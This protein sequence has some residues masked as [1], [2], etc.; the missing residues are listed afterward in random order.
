M[1]TFPPDYPRS[2]AVLLGT[3]V[4]RDKGLRQ[5]PAARNSLNGVKEILTDE[6]LC[7][8][9]EER[10]EVLLNQQHRPRLI[11]DLRRWARET[12]DVLIVYFVGHGIITPQGELCLALTDTA[13][14]DPDVTGL[15]YR[16][17]RSAL[18]DS[19][20]RMKVVVL[21][22]C[23]SGRAIQALSSSED[24]G[25][26]R[27][28]YVIAASDHAAH[29]PPPTE[30]PL[31]CTSFTGELLELIRTGIPGAPDMLTLHTIYTHLR[32][33]L[34]SAQLPDPNH[35]DT[36]TAGDFCLTRNAAY[37]P[38]PIERFPRPAPRSPLARWSWRARV[39]AMAAAVLLVGATYLVTRATAAA[40]SLCGGANPGPA[41]SGVVIGS[42]DFPESQ[43]IAQIYADALEAS[44]VPVTIESGLSSREIYYP[45]LRSGQITIFPEYN[46]A[47]LTTCV[48]PAST[49]I[50]TSQVDAALA[51]GLPSTLTILQPSPAQDRDSVTV[52]QA[53][54]AK[55]HLVSIED[56]RRV[57]GDLTI[58]GPSEFQQ[59]EQGL[60][61]L[62][63]VYGVNFGHF[64]VLDDSGP[65]SLAALLSG[66]VQAADIF[67]TDP[68]IKEYHLV[69]LTDPKH[70]FSTGNIVPL[71]YRPGVNRTITDTLN[72]VSARLTMA[73]LQSIDDQAFPHPGSIPAIASQ[74]LA[75]VGLVPRAVLSRFLEDHAQ[76]R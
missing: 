1:S 52:T 34:R 27:G 28:S 7:G 71:V 65:E 10:V 61:G 23:Y 57:A 6:R 32:A 9:P 69:V 48:N 14:D 31:A 53:T 73:S 39:L 46:G 13:L 67:T 75:Q 33:R 30:Q 3:S 76:M 54:A 41:A 21:D 8:W 29:V 50:T 15:E 4:Y 45:E 2:R 55:Y 20:A 47:L 16:Y 64:E 19:P 59:R 62:R 68:V 44:N 63:T 12:T 35:W 74:W 49:A 66:Q 5:L 26:I 18:I 37:L 42:G 56:L 72:A 40:P 60:L 70:L 58:G 38:E 51:A 43:L 25:D 36:D 11:T 24:F 17:I 22:C